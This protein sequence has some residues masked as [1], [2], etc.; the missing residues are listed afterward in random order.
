M[1]IQGFL[2]KARLKQDFGKV[3]A[4]LVPYT[5]FVLKDVGTIIRALLHGKR[6]NKY[7]QLF[8]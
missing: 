8:D 5:D 1:T 4:R 2:F 6:G 7:E 3:I